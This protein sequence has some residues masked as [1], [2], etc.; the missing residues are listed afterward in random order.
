MPEQ[1]YTLDKY[2]VQQPSHPPCGQ[3]S[4]HPHFPDGKTEAQHHVTSAPGG[5]HSS[6][7]GMGGLSK[8]S[9][10]ARPVAPVGGRQAVLPQPRHM[11]EPHAEKT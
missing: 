2:E 8:G 3:S 6:A 1:V 11:E 9:P 4:Y 7:D 10:P 5:G